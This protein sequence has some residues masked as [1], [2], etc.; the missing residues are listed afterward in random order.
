MLLE[1]NH[2]TLFAQGGNPAASQDDIPGDIRVRKAVA[3]L[4]DA[5][6]VVNV[7]EELT[8]L[9]EFTG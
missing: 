8:L 7:S 5:E 9:E 1:T 4:Q 6:A 2:E 3:E